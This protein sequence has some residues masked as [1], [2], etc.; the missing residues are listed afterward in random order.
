MLLF[1]EFNTP[2]REDNLF[3]LERRKRKFLDGIFFVRRLTQRRMMHL[4]LLSVVV[5]RAKPFETNARR[6]VRNSGEEKRLR[7][8]TRVRFQVLV[9][10]L[11]GYRVKRVL[12]FDFQRRRARDAFNYSSPS[13]QVL[14]DNKRCIERGLVEVKY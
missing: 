9:S 4:F 6:E 8:F 11:R 14:R 13:K 2:G 1:F 10:K 3:V 5:F 7:A 12:H